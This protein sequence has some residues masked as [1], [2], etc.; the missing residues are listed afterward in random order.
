MRPL[1]EFVV[2]TNIPSVSCCGAPPKWLWESV[3]I[4]TSSSKLQQGRFPGAIGVIF[5]TKF[6][7]QALHR[8]LPQSN[9]NLYSH[10]HQNWPSHRYQPVPFHLFYVLSFICL[11]YLSS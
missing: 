11:S 1:A 5:G 9:Q 7:L 2:E 8:L 10:L 3:I 4:V 6:R